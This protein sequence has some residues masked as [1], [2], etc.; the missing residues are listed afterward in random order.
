MHAKRSIPPAKCLRQSRFQPSVEAKRERM[1]MTE[2]KKRGRPKGSRTKPA[3][4]TALRAKDKIELKNSLMNSIRFADEIRNLLREKML[5]DFFRETQRAL[6]SNGEVKLTEKIGPKNVS[7]VPDEVLNTISMD[8]LG[9]MTNT[10]KEL[11]KIML[12]NGRALTEGSK[13]PVRSEGDTKADDGVI[14]GYE[15]LFQK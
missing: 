3:G 15:S 6:E 5:R 12:D 10:L 14:E 9:E 8:S 13:A 2:T 4:D 7:R 1:K 11:S